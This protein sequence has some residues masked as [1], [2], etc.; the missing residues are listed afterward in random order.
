MALQNTRFGAEKISAMMEGRKR[1]FFDGIGGV[2]MNA[3]A[4]MSMLAGYDVAGYDRTRTD[5]TEKLEKSGARVYYKA[6]ARHMKDRDILIYTVAIPEDNPE[7]RY[8]KK[9]GIPCISRSDYLG[10]LMTGYKNRIGISGTHG[11]STT[12]AMIGRI[13]AEDGDDPTVLN[14]AVM[15]ETGTVDIIGGSDFFVF[16]ACEYMDSFLDFRPTVAVVLN[17]ELDHVDY[18]KSIG[19]LIESF[20]KFVSLTGEQGTA[21]INANDPDCIEAVRGTGCRVVTFAHSNPLADYYSD[22]ETDNGGYPEFDIM[23]GGKKLAHV[24]LRIPGEHSV[25]DA[26]AAFAA[27]SV[28]G[29]D[30][31]KAASALSSYEGI[32]RRM[33]KICD[34]KEGAA[35][36]SDY[37]HHP[38]EIGT[39]LRGIRKICRG[40]L[41]V[42]YQ[43]HTYSRTAELY[44]DFVD[45]FAKGDADKL[46]FCDIY[47]ARETN[48]YGVT[49]EKLA[50]DIA[51]R[52]KDATAAGSFGEAADMA[53]ASSGD[54]DVIVVMGAGDVEK[55]AEII[56]KQSD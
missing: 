22:N 27:V 16:E 31:E 30:P 52:G 41:T 53:L 14:G 43:P 55:V 20:G 50:R 4:H 11:K 36:Y 35:V 17:V 5:I 24:R 25:S 40:R 48:T 2:S 38:T 15:K 37:A 54:G 49:S 7:Y 32:K 13:L 42:V 1:L 12:T 8:A 56:K 26:L 23:S 44:D 21:V 45:V 34:T 18:F 29:V 3:L 39:T 47:A 10:Y 9:N 6:D 51:A 46:I 33:E 19:Q 28:F